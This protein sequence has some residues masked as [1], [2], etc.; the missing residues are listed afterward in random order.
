MKL[1]NIGVI[2]DNIYIVRNCQ[3]EFAFELPSVIVARHSEHFSIKY[4]VC[5]N[6]FGKSV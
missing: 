6:G 1:F 3:K 4:K 2:D 5:V